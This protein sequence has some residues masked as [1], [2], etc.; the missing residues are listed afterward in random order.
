MS[1]ATYVDPHDLTDGCI[2]LFRVIEVDGDDMRPADILLCIRMLRG[3]LRE[4]QMGYI[5]NHNKTTTEV[6]I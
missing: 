6:K 5:H 1:S 2:K 3:H 4:E